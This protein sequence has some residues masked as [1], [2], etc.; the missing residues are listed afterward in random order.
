MYVGLQGETRLRRTRRKPFSV[1][2]S[3][4]LHAGIFWLLMA[5]PPI[6][7]PARAPSEYKQ[8]IEGNEA[9]IVWYKLPEK[10]PKVN[11]EAPRREK[12]RLRAETLS[13]QA[14]I[15][16]PPRAQKSPQMVWADAPAIDTQPLTDSA[17]MIAVMEQ[18][19][20]PKPFVTPKDAVRP[21]APEIAI[22]EGPAIPV[23][24]R[25][26]EQIAG[27]LPGKP[28]TPPRERA[29]A[30]AR[31]IETPE[32]PEVKPSRL[33]SA[34]VATKLPPKPYV[35][36]ESRARVQRE[37]EVAVEIP[38]D[39]PQLETGRA[40]VTNLAVNK[41]PPRPYQAARQTEGKAKEIEVGTPPALDG[42]LSKLSVAVVGLNPGTAAVT[43]PAFS[44][45]AAFSGGAKL[46][47][48]G[49]TSDG[50]TAGLTVPNLFVKNPAAE[51]DRRPGKAD[52]LARA[53]AAPTAPETIREAL[54][55][56]QPVAAIPVT[57]MP[58]K[59]GLAGATRVSGAPTGRFNN[60]EVYMMAIQM[61][62]LSSFSGSWL[63]WYSDKTARGAGLA[64]LTPPVAH[65]KVDPKYFADAVEERKEGTV[66]L[67]CVIDKEGLVSGVE[68]L[69]GFDPRLDQSAREA[70]A[71]W[72]FYPA[73]RQNEA[74]EVE[75]VVEIP[76]RL[77]P[78]TGKQ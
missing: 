28:F 12:R 30:P 70:L 1:L 52:L 54:R 69:K 23:D 27:R 15:S 59:D 3:L 53:Y 67:F 24:V 21:P 7:L 36:A 51:T 63:M 45:P 11:S 78:R 39:A 65:R 49:A 33:D 43:L 20:P 31:E 60:R 26:P 8:A 40:A 62:N 22:A 29:R 58:R 17:N 18:P 13:K 56:A 73:T 34:I 32:A 48:E 68:I 2:A 5:A 4:A 37:I 25:M 14:I 44:N 74:V 64:P 66:Q 41:L 77:A 61:P 75:V 6:E 9:H 38:T 47:P 46:N 19:L 42:D 10:L 76:F 16:S 50:K 57:A 72:E 55:R 71:K 35:A